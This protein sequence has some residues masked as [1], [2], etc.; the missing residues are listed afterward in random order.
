MT[1]RPSPLSALSYVGLV[2][3]LLTLLWSAT[4]AWFNLVQR[5]SII[6]VH[7]RFM[8]GDVAGYLSKGSG[9]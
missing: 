1:P 4:S 5:V 9:Q 6:E 8:H 3:S 2:V 7:E